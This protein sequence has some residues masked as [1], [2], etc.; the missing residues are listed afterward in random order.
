M[1]AVEPQPTPGQAPE[2][3]PGQEPTVTPP[4]EGTPPGQEPPGDSTEIQRLRQEAAKHRREAREAQE[5]LKAI[6]D[7]ALSEEQR[8]EQALT[9]ATAERDELKAKA[10]AAT[11]RADVV[12]AAARLGIVDPD[13]AYRLM[14]PVDVDADDYPEQVEAS[15]TALLEKRPYLKAAAAGDPPP[16]D[17]PAIP[18]SNPQKPGD[19]KEL[20]TE[21]LSRMTR[22]QVAGLPKGAFEAA[23]KR[24]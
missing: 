20:T 24:G 16:K 23:L 17:P 8:R 6:E 4:P 7:A 12:I 10:A 9:T 1:S 19:V 21:D 5:R 3:V 13:A 22:D 18:P 15:L 11:L 2:V 14:D